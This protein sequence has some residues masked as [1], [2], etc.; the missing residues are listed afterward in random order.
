MCGFHATYDGPRVRV[1]PK[2]QVIEFEPIS[3]QETFKVRIKRLAVG[4]CGAEFSSLNPRSMI[5]VWPTF[6]CVP[7]SSK[8]LKPLPLALFELVGATIHETFVYK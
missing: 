8:S 2:P 7:L 6:V 1:L 4:H 3:E 5:C